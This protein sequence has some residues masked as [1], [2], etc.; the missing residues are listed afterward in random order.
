[1][2]YGTGTDRPLGQQQLRFVEEYLKDPTSARA[3]A[4]RAGY[5]IQSARVHA[6]ELMKDPR[7]KQMISLSSAVAADHLVLTAERVLQELALIAFAKTDG[8]VSKDADGDDTVDFQSLSRSNPKSPTEVIVNTVKGKGKVQSVTV[9][10]V[11]LADKI[12]ALDK[13]GKHF[14]LFKD[15]VEVTG[16]LSLTELIEASFKMPEVKPIIQPVSSLIEYK[17]EPEVLKEQDQDSDE[18][19]GLEVNIPL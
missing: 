9:K 12:A 5:S 10:S 6:Y 16:N 2:A 8:L 7:I 11:K 13:L 15:K 19:L 18:V 17:D 3:A 1:M 4:R 14:D